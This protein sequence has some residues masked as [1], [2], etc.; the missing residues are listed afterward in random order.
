MTDLGPVIEISAH[1]AA[2]G[3][4]RAVADALN[5]WFRWVVDGSPEPMPPC[6]GPL[7]VD[8]T[9]YRWSL[10]EDVDW[11]LGPH[12]RVAGEEVRIAIHTRDTAVR[13]AGLLRALGGA[14]VRLAR[15]EGDVG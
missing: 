4:P 10:E 15:D 2:P 5:R 14:Q 7:G 13:V 1:F 8:D 11:T 12:A 6:F 3:R 9:T